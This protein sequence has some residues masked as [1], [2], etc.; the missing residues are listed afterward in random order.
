MQTQN[1]N[2]KTAASES[3]ETGGKTRFYPSA[4]EPGISLR[5]DIYQAQFSIE[6]TGG[7]T[8]PEDDSEP[9]SG[10]QYSM[11]VW[12]FGAF[13]SLSDA[14]SSIE[15]LYA[16][17]EAGE[18]KTSFSQLV[19][20]TPGDQF[21]PEFVRVIDR[22]NDLALGAVVDHGVH[23]VAPV[24]TLRDLVQVMGNIENS[25]DG[26]CETVQEKNRQLALI[27]YRYWKHPE[28]ESLI[29]RIASP[30]INVF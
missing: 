1:V 22:H 29:N 11:G 7:Y 14:V 2:V 17:W 10:L 9:G 23:W 4:Y 26:G 15:A 24:E 6:I 20:G 3:K 16:Q 13:A 30:A 27:H 8:Y 18:Y 28:V 25:K 12:T 5:E 19:Y 21:T